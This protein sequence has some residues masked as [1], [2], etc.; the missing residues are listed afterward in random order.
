MSVLGRQV[1]EPSP[2]RLRATAHALKRVRVDPVPPNRRTEQHP[3][4]LDFFADFCLGVVLFDQP[5]PPR[6]ALSGA[7]CVEV[8][9]FAEVFAEQPSRLFV[10]CERA[11]FDR[12]PLECRVH[13]FAERACFGLL[14]IL[15][16]PDP[17]QFAVHRIGQLGEPRRRLWIG[18]GV[19][20]LS[21][22]EPFE[23]Y[24]E[25]F[26]VLVRYFAE[27]DRSPVSVGINEQ[28]PLSPARI[29]RD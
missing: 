14:P 9:V 5:R 25:R 10:A 2:I 21:V 3:G 26:R 17:N 6:I 24:S 4:D 12:H 23:P 15:G 11:G 19:R 7:D 28:D 1:V 29:I 8:A 27:P 13:Q 22:D 20:P 16:Q 18:G